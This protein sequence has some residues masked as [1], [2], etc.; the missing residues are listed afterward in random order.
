MKAIEFNTKLHSPDAIEIPASYQD[1]LKSDQ[2]VRVIVLIEDA[3]D[4]ESWKKYTTTQFF[5]GYSDE[6]A[7]YDELQ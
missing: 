3:T 6:D 2:N 4:E 1:Q 7:V 5:S